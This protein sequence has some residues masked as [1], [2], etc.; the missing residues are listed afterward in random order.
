M[1][2]TFDPNAKIGLGNVSE[3]AFANEE[4]KKQFM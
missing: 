1:A 4:E 3:G 2:D